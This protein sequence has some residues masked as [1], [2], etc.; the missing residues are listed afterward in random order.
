MDEKA[1]ADEI[2]KALGAWPTGNLCNA[3]AGVRAME[4]SIKPLADG[5]R[6]SGPARTA[7]IAPGQNAAIHR[8]VHAGRAGEIL[9]VDGGGSRSWGPF[10]DILATCCRNQGIAGLVIDSTV[11]DAAEL[12]E[13]EFPVFCLGTNPSATAK[14]E[15]G[16]T[17]VDIQCGQVPVSPG[18]FIVADD[19]G[20]VVIPQAIAA[21]VVRLVREVGQREDA[22]MKQLA[23]G[24]TTAE[25]FK[26][27]PGS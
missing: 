12:R 14:T 5:M 26:L 24:K 27:V 3:H 8:A 21:D 17:D 6:L 7:I 19:S 15:P 16:E 22:I 18:D 2:A 10:G 9:V 4:A 20:V 25:I 23:E 13:M 1:E 11:R